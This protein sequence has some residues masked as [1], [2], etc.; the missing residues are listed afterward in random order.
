MT[1]DLR[2]ELTAAY[3]DVSLAIQKALSPTSNI[4]P[5]SVVTTLADQIKK[6][7]TSGAL[8]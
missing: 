8:L 5:A 7:L 4:N 1:T 3:A 2:A 6:S